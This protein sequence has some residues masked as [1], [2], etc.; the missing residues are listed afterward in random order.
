MQHLADYFWSR[1]RKE[2]PR[3]SSDPKWTQPQKNQCT[4]YIFI[5]KDDNLSR[6]HCV[7]EVSEGKDANVRSVKL[8]V[9]DTTLDS[10]GKKTRPAKVLERPVHELVLLVR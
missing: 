3:Q 9:A 10:K 2:F 8:I 7:T 6:N 1:W 4:G 5:I